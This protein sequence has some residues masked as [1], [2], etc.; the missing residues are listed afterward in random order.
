MPWRSEARVASEAEGSE[1]LISRAGLAGSLC[2]KSILHIDLSAIVSA[3]GQL[4]CAP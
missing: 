1:D 2:R 4:E 3:R